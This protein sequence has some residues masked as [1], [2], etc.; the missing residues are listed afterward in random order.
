MHSQNRAMLEREVTLHN[1]MSGAPSKEG[2][3]EFM[4]YAAKIRDQLKDVS[5]HNQD[6]LHMSAK[7]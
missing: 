5:A 3:E 1:V 7:L 4:H 2:S 6:S